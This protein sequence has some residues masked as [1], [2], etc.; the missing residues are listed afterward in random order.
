M[1]LVLYNIPPIVRLAFCINIGIHECMNL[2]RWLGPLGFALAKGL[3]RG[4]INRCPDP[5][6]ATKTD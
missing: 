6:S 5:S 4:L 1:C 3:I 2:K